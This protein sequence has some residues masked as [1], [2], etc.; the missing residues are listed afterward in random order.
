MK[1]KLSITLKSFQVPSFVVHEV[2]AGERQ[3]GFR[4]TPKSRVGD[5]SDETLTALCDE[6][7]DNIFAKAAIQRS[8]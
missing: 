8:T 6:F 5:L 3:N 7:R 2:E 1:A 4:E